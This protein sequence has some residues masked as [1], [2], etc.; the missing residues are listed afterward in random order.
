MSIS[1]TTNFY[2]KIYLESIPEF[3]EIREYCLSEDNWLRENY[4]KENL[5]LEKMNGY[6]VVFEKNT[7]EPVGMAGLYNGGIYPD[8]IGKHLHREYAFPKFRQRTYSGF[9]DGFKVYREHLIN[10][11]NAI[12][13]QYNA[14]FIGMQTRYKKQS[15]GYWNIF[16]N[17]LI[18]AIP[19]WKLGKGYIRT[20]NHDVQKCFQNYAYFESE[21]GTFNCPLSVITQGQWDN[22]IQGD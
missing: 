7:N 11:L 20:C 15:K 22:L 6:A 17:A 14:F 19:G 3:E 8:N 2:Y 18:E 10:P 12:N 4:T 5:V 9:V 13:P 1:D 21:D 16:T